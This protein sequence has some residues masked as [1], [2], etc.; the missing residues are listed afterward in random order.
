MELIFSEYVTTNKEAFLA[1]VKQVASSLGIDPNALMAVMFKESRLNPAAVNQVSG[2]TG[3]IQFMPSTANSLGTTTGALRLMSNVQQ[4][5]FV[6]KYLR[7]YKSKMKSAIDVYFAVF[8]PAAIGWPLN[9]VLQTSRLSAALIAS[10]NSGIDSN[11]D[12]KITVGEVQDW[13][14]RGLPQSVQDALQKKNQP[15]NEN[16]SNHIFNC[17]HCGRSIS[18]RKIS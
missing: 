18:T 13:F 3:L 4:L 10:Q 16:T 15:N 2:A 6:E 12:S 7:P 9:S 8:F 5:D 17:P 1:K 11:K 14:F